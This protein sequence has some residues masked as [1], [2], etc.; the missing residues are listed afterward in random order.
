MIAAILALAVLPQVTVIDDGGRVRSTDDWKGAPAVIVPMYTRC[1]L[2]CPMVTEGLK[3]AAAQS[4]AD[5]STYRVV[6]FSFDPR[7]TPADLHAYRERHAVPLGW[8]LATAKPA[9]V[10]RLLDALDV[11]V[12]DAGGAFVHPNVAVVLTPDLQVAKKL[13]GT[14]F[15][16]SDLDGALEIA[17]GGTDWI[18]RY[19]SFALA[20]LLLICILSGIYLVVPFVSSS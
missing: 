1:P 12:T 14:T 3:A 17:R 5:P 16:A 8:T 2:A 10:R 7:D 13:Y 4:N 15:R 6:L 9:D 19:G 18:G 20:A 11:R